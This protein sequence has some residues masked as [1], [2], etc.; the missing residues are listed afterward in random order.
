MYSTHTYV[1]SEITRWPLL[2]SAHAR[3]REN[4]STESHLRGFCHYSHRGVHA[5]HYD[6]KTTEYKSTDSPLPPLLNVMYCGRVS[7]WTVNIFLAQ[8]REKG[9]WVISEYLWF[10]PFFSLKLYPCLFP[11]VS[12]LNLEDCV[13][14]ISPETLVVGSN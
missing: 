3:E 13:H 5:G 6:C 7:L 11:K 4:I 10:M 1:N 12:L 2:R 14:I 8:Y 9:S